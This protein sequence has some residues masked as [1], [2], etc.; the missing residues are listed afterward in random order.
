[1]LDANYFGSDLPRSNFY[2]SEPLQ[3]AGFE[4]R[5]GAYK[6]AGNPNP[7]GDH[8]VAPWVRHAN[9]GHNGIRYFVDDFG[10]VW[11][12][13]SHFQAPSHEHD[14]CDWEFEAHLKAL[15]AKKQ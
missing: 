12:Y 3:L 11:Y 15:S 1:M 13:A 6:P 7:H 14:H 2:A 5:G 9:N 10:D 4:W 8:L